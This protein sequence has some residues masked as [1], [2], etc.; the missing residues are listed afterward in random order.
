MYVKCSNVKADWPR[1]GP[2]CE[3]QFP[4]LPWKTAWIWISMDIFMDIML[5][6]LLI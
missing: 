3:S 2:F 6:R 5:T 1:H 4:G